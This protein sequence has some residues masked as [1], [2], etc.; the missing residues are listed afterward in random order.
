[1]SKYGPEKAPYLDTFHAVKLMAKRKVYSHE[2]RT[3]K[4]WKHF[5]F[6]FY[7]FARSSFKIVDILLKNLKVYQETPPIEKF[8]ARKKP[9]QS[10]CI[11]NQL[12]KL[13]PKWH[14]LNLGNHN[15]NKSNA[16]KIFFA[17]STWK[18]MLVPRLF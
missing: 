6:F 17:Q 8:A 16:D 18:I 4:K 3:S 7:M 12:I 11:I 5:P 1:M 15:S 10:I 9:L 13:F 14:Y 2:E